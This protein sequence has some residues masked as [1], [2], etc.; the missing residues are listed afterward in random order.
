MNFLSINIFMNEYCARLNLDIP[1]LSSRIDI[2][3]FKQRYLARHGEQE[4]WNN[5]FSAGFWS[6]WML[7]NLVDLKKALEFIR[8]KFNF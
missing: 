6:R 1:L 4:D 3:K 7:W 5:I 8:H 2:N